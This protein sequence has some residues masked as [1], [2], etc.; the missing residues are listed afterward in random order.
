M[1]E[2]VRVGMLKGVT[3]WVLAM[4]REVGHVFKAGLEVRR[5]EGTVGIT[6]GLPLVQWG[7]SL[8]GEGAQRTTAHRV[9]VG[10]TLGEVAAPIQNKLEAV[11][12]HT[13]VAVV[14]LLRLVVT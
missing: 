11:G 10:D 4:E 14:A 3:E 9:E 6:G 2:W 7:D 5:E 13:V 12:V 1:E 8:V